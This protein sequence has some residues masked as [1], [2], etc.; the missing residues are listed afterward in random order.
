M[1][2][3]ETHVENYSTDTLITTRLSQ[4]DIAR[5]SDVILRRA[6]EMVARDIADRFLAD[7]AQEILACLDPQAVAN[8]AVAD[9]AASVREALH[10]KLP[11]KIVDVVRTE[12]EVWQRGIFGGMRRIG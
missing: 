9:S 3:M 11:D 7:K 8:L 6:F 12:S 5:F 4:H 2:S 10:K 1:A